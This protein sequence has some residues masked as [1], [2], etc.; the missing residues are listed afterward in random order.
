MHDQSWDGSLEGTITVP[1][2]MLADKLVLFA[3]PYCSDHVPQYGDRYSVVA[4]P[5]VDGQVLEFQLD[6]HW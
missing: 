2:N 4:G 3:E 6:R 5:F 1:R